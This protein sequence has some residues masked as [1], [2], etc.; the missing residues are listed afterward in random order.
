MNLV[1]GASRI[2]RGNKWLTAQDIGLKRAAW[3]MGVAVDEQ[4]D[5]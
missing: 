4:K 2:V 1:L 5:K 3:K